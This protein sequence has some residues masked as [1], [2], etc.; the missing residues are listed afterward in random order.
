MSRDARRTATET[1]RAP[2][3]ASRWKTVLTVGIGAFYLLP[4]YIALS[5]A[6]R[7]STDS[8]SL[9][10]PPR[11]LYLQNFVD[12]FRQGGVGRS[13]LNSLV[14]TA[15][16]IVTIALIGAFAAYPLARRRTR[17]NS[18]I[19]GFVLGVMMVPPLSV[20][21]AL[22]TTM[23]GLHGVSTYWGIV[24]TIT[25]FELPLSIFL[26]SNFIAAIPSALDE[27]A[28]IDGAGVARTFFSII[29]PQLK[30]VTA[31]VVILTGMH[32]WNDYQFSLYMLQKP[33]MRTL[34]LAIASFFSQ[35]TSNVYAATAA[36][37]V[38]MLPAILL[39]V[40]LQ[41]YF[42]KGMVDSAIK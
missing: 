28:A 42:I 39:F 38:A 26:Y 20:L 32:A 33:Q 4:I 9:W 22:Y 15:C 17:V 2:G 35:T 14:I 18:G 21:V 12:A 24:V 40:V 16:C 1:D 6:F 30:P 11:S 25:A 8:R 31:S 13:M 19:K 10:L 5:V 29:L 37:L 36:A 41:R 27:A 34:P 3:H 7:P 23:A